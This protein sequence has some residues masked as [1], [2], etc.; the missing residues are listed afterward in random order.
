MRAALADCRASGVS[1]T[2]TGGYRSREEQLKLFNNEVD[3][4]MGAGRSADTAYAI[5]EQRIG[6]PGNSEHELGLALDFQ[7]AEAQAWLKENAWRYG[8]ILRY[9]EG[10]EDITG[11]S[12][13][14]AHYRFVGVA[15]AEQIASL[16]ITLEEYMGLFFTQEAEIIF[17]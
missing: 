7:G 12:P 15:A 8:F 9:P 1:I 4:Q 3:R 11:R 14:G 10:S 6:A 13:D 5:A 17:D 16:E 2:L